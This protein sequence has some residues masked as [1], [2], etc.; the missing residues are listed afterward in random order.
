M[1]CRVPIHTKIPEKK[2]GWAVPG[3]T[4]PLDTCIEM[5]Q[6]L[7]G[8]MQQF[9]C[10][11]V[12]LEDT[13]GIL[14]YHIAKRAAA[15]EIVLLPGTVTYAVYWIERPYNVYWWR[16]PQGKTLAFYCNIAD[17]TRLSA[18]EFH[19]RDLT[20]D[21]L[22]LPGG[23]ITILDQEQLPADLPGSL[24]N[25]IDCAKQHVVQNARR[26]TEEVQELVER[27]S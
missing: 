22:I 8:A 11:L 17:S 3:V 5:K 16:N 10:E 2:Q 25:Y 1:Y 14:R 23:E 27:H 12:A 19:W 4:M 26:I 7:S 21:V 13:Y 18:D 6:T 24:R 15:G 20:L 9:T